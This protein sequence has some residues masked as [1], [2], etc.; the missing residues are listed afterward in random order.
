VRERDARRLVPRW[1]D[2]SGELAEVA[3]AQGW[4][5]VLPGPGDP[6]VEA[7]EAAPGT[8][9][10]WY[11]D[12]DTDVEYAVVDGPDRAAA[13]DALRSRIEM[14]T[15][16]NAAAAVAAHRAPLLRG[17]TLMAVAVAAPPAPDQRVADVIAAALADADPYVRRY[18]L[19]AT[20]VLGWPDLVSR[21]EEVRADDP[22]SEVRATAAEILS[23]R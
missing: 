7:W 11:E 17:R 22:D 23:R 9:V 8:L 14:L 13:E 2:A 10:T 20:E 1:P 12:P 18:G 3:R 15:P 4:R 19:Y 16:D 5:E 21:A 6:W